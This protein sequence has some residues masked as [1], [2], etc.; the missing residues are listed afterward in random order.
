MCIGP[1]V[2]IGISTDGSL[3]LT[4]TTLA[5]RAGGIS[6]TM[7][8]AVSPSDP[9]VE[10]PTGTSGPMHI[11]WFRLVDGRMPQHRGDVEWMQVY[12]HRPLMTMDEAAGF[13]S[14]Q[15]R[16]QLEH[17]TLDEWWD[18]RRYQHRIGEVDV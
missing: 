11:N 9:F 14:P 8:V 15:W 4:A 1:R 3:E 6:R 18:S 10:N 12:R 13:V 7:V 17:T 2:P 16:A 5:R